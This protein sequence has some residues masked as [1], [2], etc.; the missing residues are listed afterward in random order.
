[1]SNFYYQVKGSLYR[2]KGNQEDL[3]EIN[4]IFKNQEPI[5]ARE[6]AFEVY[7]NYID[8]LLESKNLT[9]EDHRK[10]I[11]ATQDFI[12]NEAVEISPF[13]SEIFGSI[14]NDFD[15]GISI[16]LIFSDSKAF[17]T[18]EGEL[19]YENKILIH[20][21]N[22]EIKGLKDIMYR[23][24]L[25]EF[26][27]YKKFDLSCKDYRMALACVE[28]NAGNKYEYILKTPIHHQITHCLKNI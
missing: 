19:I 5:L 4:E 15:K 24:L 25:Q 23:G 17:T 18:L 26:E 28:K 16:Y 3:I 1:M 20:D 12:S 8:V 11:K 2:S 22:S 13:L 7:Q 6:R 27:L 9:Y 10:T 21:L 14:E